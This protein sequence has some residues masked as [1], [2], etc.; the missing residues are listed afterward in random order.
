VSL[1]YPSGTLL[2]LGAVAHLTH[3]PVRTLCLRGRHIRADQA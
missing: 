3:S 1:S 2:P